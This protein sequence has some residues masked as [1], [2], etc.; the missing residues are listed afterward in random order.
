MCTAITLNDRD[1]YFGRTLDLEYSYEECAAVTPRGF[2]FGFRCGKA[3]KSYALIGTAY[4][5]DGYP[6]YYEAA[7]ECGLAMAGLDFRG[8]AM[9]FPEQEG[10]I[11]LAPHEFIPWVLT[12]SENLEEAK[13][14]LKN[15]NLINK[16]FSKELPPAPLHWLIADRTGAVTAESV[17][18]G[19]KIH[20]N[21][22]GVLTNNPPFEYHLTRMSDYAGLSNKSPENA[23]GMPE[24]RFYSR[25]MGAIGLPGDFSSV[26][27][28]VRA[29][30]MKLNSAPC[31]SEAERVSRFFHILSSVRQVRGC[32][33]LENGET[34]IT[35]YTS[36]I[37]ADKGIFYYITYENSCVTC[38]EM[39]KEKLDAEEIRIFPLVK[40]GFMNRQN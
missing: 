33:E 28:F 8:Y 22:V 31:A 7:N 9:Y 6:L 40:K 3:P 39:R 1:F 2:D 29:A 10:K 14:K 26:S 5:K 4:V 30:F 16:G 13:E 25:G 12:G 27:R 18:E 23:F 21:P 35:H 37:N 19:L 15:V 17:P 20:E 38:V 32:T 11:N 36:C 24:T 34:V